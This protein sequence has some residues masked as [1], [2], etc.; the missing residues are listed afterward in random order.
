[1]QTI[2]GQDCKQES[3]RGCMGAGRC[4][5]WLYLKA[6]EALECVAGD[7]TSFC[8]FIFSIHFYPQPSACKHSFRTKMKPENNAVIKSPVF[9]IGLQKKNV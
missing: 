3:A 5:L 8:A 2:M 6:G 9:F 7:M 4:Y 1:M